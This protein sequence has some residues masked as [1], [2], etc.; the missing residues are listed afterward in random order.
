[1]IPPKE[2]AT[3]FFPPSERAGSI[4]L[5]PLTLAGV[6][7]L[8][9]LGIS[10]GSPIPAE[11][12]FETAFVLST[13]HEP[14]TTGRDYRRFL[15]HAKC[16]LAEL[17]RAVAR[18]LDSAYSTWIRPAKAEGAGNVVRLTPHGIGWALEYAEWLCAEYGWSFEEAMATPVA[19][20]FALAAACRERNGGRHAGLDYVE[21]WYEGE[22]KAGR[23]K[24]PGLD[25]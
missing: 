24:A 8:A 11:R 15:R 7:R 20:V 14:R 4:V 12:L 16:G 18:V 6:V 22:V 9:E 13:S 3:A 25:I 5:R 10:T 1:M 17:D 2:N 19:R 23:A 21:R